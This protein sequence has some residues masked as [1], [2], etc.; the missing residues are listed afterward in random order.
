LTSNSASPSNHPQAMK[1]TLTVLYSTLCLLQSTLL[2]VIPTVGGISTAFAQESADSIRITHTQ[3]TGTLEKQRFIDR[4]D[5]VFMTKEPTKWLLKGYADIINLLASH[6]FQRSY[7]NHVVDFRLG[8]EYKISPSFSIGVDVTRLVNRPVTPDGL[9]DYSY[10]YSSNF[11]RNW[12]TSAE[13]RWYH[14]MASRIKRGKSSNN[15]FGNY[16]SLRYEKLW[17]NN[18][19]ISNSLSG[20]DGKWDTDYFSNYYDSQLSLSYGIQRRLFRYGLIDMALSLNRRTDQQ[21]HRQLTFLD[22]DNSVKL[23][24][25]WNNIRQSI[26]SEPQHNWSIT[27]HFKIGVALADFKKTAKTPHDLLQ[28]L[29]NERSLWKFSWPK[30]HLS[31]S[32][33]LFHGSIG[34]EHKIAQSPLSINSYLDLSASNSFQKNVSLYNPETGTSFRGNSQGLILTAKLAIQPRW[35]LFMNRQMPLGKSG[36]NLSGLYAGLNTIFFGSHSSLKTELYKNS[37]TFTPTF[38]NTGLLLGY[39]RKLFK[40]GFVDLNLTKGLLDRKPY[41]LG[42]NNFLLDLKLGF[43]L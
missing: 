19:S 38:I 43:A 5:Y 26:T 10:I 42:I 15:F 8:A 13:L 25:D 41:V 22:G 33:Q 9:T 7:V 16:V 30:I 11:S 1:K 2:F 28:C 23:P 29:E 20:Y 37:F 14:D 17:Q 39:Q 21:V 3:E 6:L 24:V 35:Y 12:R 32:T 36:N 27:T 4:Y 34:H 40:N 18:Q 31:T